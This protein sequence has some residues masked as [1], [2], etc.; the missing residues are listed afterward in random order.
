MPPVKESNFSNSI[1]SY[2]T[3]TVMNLFFLRTGFHHYISWLS[4]IVCCISGYLQYV[5]PY[6]YSMSVKKFIFIF[7]SLEN[8]Y[9]VCYGFNSKIFEESCNKPAIITLSAEDNWDMEEGTLMSQ[10]DLMGVYYKEDNISDLDTVLS[11]KQ[12]NPD[13]GYVLFYNSSNRIWYAGKSADIPI[14]RNLKSS[15]EPIPTANWE[16]FNS[17]IWVVDDTFEATEGEPIYPTGFQISSLKL[18]KHEQST[19][20]GTYNRTETIYNKR[21]VWKH[22]VYERYLF[23]AESGYWV[24]ASNLQCCLASLAPR[25]M[26]HVQVPRSTWT[27]YNSF[28]NL[29]DIY[30]NWPW[31]KSLNV[32]AIMSV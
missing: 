5:L 21:P 11:W 23:F 30:I 24:V 32:T 16:Y 9:L 17:R 29:Y 3:Q 27:Y 6:K 8:Y 28:D 4:Y 12:R 18:A 26:G 2:V 19:S 20:M 22:T 10:P 1:Y 31:D 13:Y 7:L 25:S 15:D 14:L